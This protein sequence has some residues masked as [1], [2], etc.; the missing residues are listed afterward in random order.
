MQ[1]IQAQ[2]NDLLYMVFTPELDPIG[3]SRVGEEISL[4]TPHRAGLADVGIEIRRA[5][6]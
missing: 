5:Q 2:L 4:L 1:T 3:F 6:P